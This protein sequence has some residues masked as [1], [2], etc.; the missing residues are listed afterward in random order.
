MSVS[1]R[2]AP[3][4]GFTPAPARPASTLILLREHEGET[5][6]LLL[7]RSNDID[8]AAGALVFPGGRLEEADRDPHLL[9]RTHGVAGYAP[10]LAALIVAA[11]RETFEES[12]LLMARQEGEDALVEPAR[13]AA[14]APKREAIA[15]SALSFRAFLE[16]E[17]LALAG[18]LIRPLCRWV[19]PW[20]QPKRYDTYFFI[21]MAPAGQEALHEGREALESLWISA[22]RARKA[23]AAGRVR[24]MTPTACHL[25]RMERVAGL[26]ETLAIEGAALDAPIEPYLEP[27]GGGYR[28]GLDL[29]AGYRFRAREGLSLEQLGIR[30]ALAAALAEIG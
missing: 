13:A 3:P 4:A 28:M 21:G 10:E 8:F 9:A 20:W 30:G 17:K 24:L 15:Q 19:T 23:A 5:Q 25:E 29:P 12:G 22:K 26:A 2:L 6:T 1:G 16:A 18:D 27:Y 7:R 14:F 11:I